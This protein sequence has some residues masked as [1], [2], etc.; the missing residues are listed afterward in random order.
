MSATSS[1]ATTDITVDDN[2]TWRDAFRFGI[3]DDT[4][5][6]FTGASFIMEVKADVNDTLPLYTLT[7]AGGEIVV[8]DA[9][10]RVLHFN[11][12]EATVRANLPVG[13]YVYDLVM[14]DGSVPPVRDLLMT[15]TVYVVRG[16]T[17]D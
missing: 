12:P 16:V 2:V 10:Q 9:V 3:E 8:D 7:S 6:S 11:V 1:A 4:T 5:W 13:V 17:G 14:F 15:G